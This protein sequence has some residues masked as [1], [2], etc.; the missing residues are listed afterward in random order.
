[1]TTLN[2]PSTAFTRS[3]A[4]SSRA[5]KVAAVVFGSLLIAAAS[6]IEVPFFPVPMTMQTFAVLLVGLLFGARL[7]AAAVLAYLAEAAVGLP[8]LSGGDALV[9]L[10]VKPATAGYLVGFVGA[11]FVAGLIAERTAGRVWGTVA[12]AVA[13]EVVLMTLGVAFLAWLI[14]VE[15]AVTYGLVPFVLGD[16]LKIVLAVA[17]ARGIGRLSLPGAR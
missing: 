5:V 1:M 2:Q 15:S 4:G 16:L 14:G 9:S 12:A 10:L 3:L 6:Q 7:G 13:G 17:V 11:A 8:V